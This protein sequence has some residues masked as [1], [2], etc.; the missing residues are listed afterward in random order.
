VSAR[1]W[2]IADG[3]TGEVLWG[4]NEDE[5]RKTASTTKIMC[6]WVVIQLAAADASVLD[7]VVTFSRLADATGG[8]TAGVR[9][10]ERVPVR[11]LLY[12][13]LLPSGNDAGNA[14]AEHFNDRLQQPEDP[15]LRDSPALATRAGFVAEMNRHARRLGMARTT[16]R[17]PYADGGSASQFTSTARDLL[18]LAWHAMQDPLFRQY[19]GTRRH[20]CVL[21]TP[22]GGERVVVWRNTNQLLPIEGY[23]GVKT[24]TTGQAG[25]C[26]VSSG[27]RGKDHLLVAVLGSAASP[28]RYYDTRNL[29]RWAWLQRGHRP[30]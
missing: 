28:C 7:E 13:L 12:G 29:F 19:V 10:G 16:Y 11:E 2:A 26:L 14:L 4:L 27:R 24:G 23:E 30:D 18:R 21:E 22:D 5:P 6:A 17:S 20:R 15:E 8:S 25:A 1:A 9:E 3:G